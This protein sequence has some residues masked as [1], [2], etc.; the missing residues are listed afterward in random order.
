M[1]TCPTNVDRAPGLVLQVQVFLRIRQKTLKCSDSIS[2]TKNGFA[3]LGI[4]FV[5]FF[6]VSLVS[7][8]SILAV[9]AVFPLFR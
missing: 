9:C 5:T 6:I 3:K 2:C 1:Q 4:H 8:I 7:L